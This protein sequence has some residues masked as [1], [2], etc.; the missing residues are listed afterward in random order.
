MSKISLIRGDS[1]NIDVGFLQSDGVT[2][3]NL[4]GGTVYF[5]VN[6][7]ADPA[8]D[9]AAAVQ[10][11]VTVHTA[12]TLGQTRITLSP[13]DTSALAAGTYYYDVQFKDSAGSV[14]SQKQDTF[15]LT[16]DITRR[17]T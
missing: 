6:S 3:V 9:T 10:K 12:P 11:N 2:P 4:T 14:L 15:I 17:T 16:A 7:S 1:R 13:T 5:T 8:D